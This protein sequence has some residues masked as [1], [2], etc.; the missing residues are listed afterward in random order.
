MFIENLPV[1]RFLNRAFSDN[2]S[3]SVKGLDIGMDE[4]DNVDRATVR[5]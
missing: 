4:G 5:R 1:K 3:E 2:L